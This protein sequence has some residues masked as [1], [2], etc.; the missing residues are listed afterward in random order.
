MQHKSQA[1]TIYRSFAKNGLKCR[2]ALAV[3]LSIILS[4][5]LV[6][7]LARAASALQ[8]T[9]STAVA[10]P[11]LVREE[12]ISMSEQSAK[13]SPETKRRLSTLPARVNPSVEVIIRVSCSLGQDQRTQLTSI[14]T[15]IR[16]VAGDV[17]T[18]SL[19]LRQIPQLAELDFV[20]YIELASPL[21]P[22]SE[23]QQ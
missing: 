5:T 10:N 17:V 2:V 15:Q 8:K 12:H 9:D 19:S 4:L 13:F 22:E 3:C 21:Y 16:T 1:M 7:L 11:H 6:S 18:A 14:G 23:N 20:S